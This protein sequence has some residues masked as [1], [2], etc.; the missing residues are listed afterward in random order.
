MRG[1]RCVGE[2]R[3]V[4]VDRTTT[5]ALAVPL[6][7]REQLVAGLVWRLLCG[8][9]M[10]PDVWRGETPLLEPDA[11]SRWERLPGLLPAEI[12]AKRS[13]NVEG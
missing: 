2:K 10:R 6:E 4:V 8:E 5:S 7:Y 11:K 13:K 3:E 9:Q 12:S 1:G